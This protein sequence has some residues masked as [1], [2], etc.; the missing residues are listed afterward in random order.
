MRYLT[1][2]AID[3]V[4]PANTLLELTRDD[5]AGD[6]PD[7]T[8]IAG[9]VHAAEELIDGYL[10][11][12]YDLPFASVPSVVPGITL[13]LVRYALYLRRPEG[14]IPEVVKEAY[15]HSIQLL[16]SIR[17]GRVTIGDQTGKPAPAPS[18]I[19]VQARPQQFGPAGLKGY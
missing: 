10:H 11:G 16:E 15:T 2:A 12:R 14:G 18:P 9:L 17:D 6:T 13:N 5:P 4:I 19:L 3:A 1:R 7:E 8:V